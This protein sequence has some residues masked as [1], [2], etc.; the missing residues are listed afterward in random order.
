MNSQN[1]KSSKDKYIA[2]TPTNKKFEVSNPL[3]DKVK[4]KGKKLD[5]QCH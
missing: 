2:C 5:V 3:S 4:V 1:G